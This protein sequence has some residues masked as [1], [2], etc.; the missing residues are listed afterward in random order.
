M[1]QAPLGLLVP[2]DSIAGY[3]SPKP[4]TEDVER[5]KALLAEAGFPN[6]AGLPAFEMLYNSDAPIH[7]KVSQAM[8][9]MWKVR[10]GVNVTYRPLERA[11]FGNTRRD[12]AF[13]IA[14]AGWY[15]DYADPTTWLD[16]F[17]TGDGNNDGQFSSPAFDALMERAAAEPDPPRRFALLRE[18]EELLTQE[19]VPFI[20]LYQYGDGFMYDER[21]VV[22]LEVNVRLLSMFKWARPAP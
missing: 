22:G 11:G 3:A 21:K 13:D 5:A 6:G 10:L 4:L 17:R 8:A 16:L 18:A 14:R 7:G 2:P 19:E 12:H 20:P 9:Q 15:G 1:H